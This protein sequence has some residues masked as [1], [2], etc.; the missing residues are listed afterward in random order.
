SEGEARAVLKVLDA[1]EEHDDVQAV[2][3]NFDI[4]D[5]ILQNVMA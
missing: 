2:Y 4:P 5:D 3:A 1:L